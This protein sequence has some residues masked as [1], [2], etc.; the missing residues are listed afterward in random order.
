MSLPQPSFRRKVCHWQRLGQQSSPGTYDGR[1]QIW[2]SKTGF[3]GSTY[4]SAFGVGPL[5]KPLRGN[6]KSENE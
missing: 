5:L 6:T 2:A 1:D 4:T 3:S